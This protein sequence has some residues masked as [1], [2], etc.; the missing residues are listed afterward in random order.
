MPGIDLKIVEHEI[1]TYLNAKPV[2]QKIHPVNPRKVAT[3]K[4]EVEKLLKAGFIYPIHLTQ[5]VS[6]PM[7]VD[8]KQGTIRVYTN[9]CDLNEACPKDNYPTLFIG[10]IIDE[11]ASCEA[12]SFMDGF[13]SYNQIQIKLKDQQK[14]AFICPWGTFAYQK[15]PFGLKNIGATF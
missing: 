3:I 4:A 8:K 5:W 15:M 11:C 6:N 12:F 1:T 2:R 13:S 14:M 10:Q 7:P 9:F